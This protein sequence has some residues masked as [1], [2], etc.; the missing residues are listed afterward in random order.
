MNIELIPVIE[1]GYNNQGISTPFDYPYWNNSEIWD[2]YHN[3]CFAKAGFKDKMKPYLAGSSF[4]KPSDISNDNLVKLIKDHTEDMRT[5][6]YSRKQACAFFGGSVLRID[7]QDKYYP[8]CCGLL[9]D[10]NY[11][12]RLANGQN[13]CYEGHPEPEIKIKNTSIVFDFSTNKNEEIFEPTPPERILKIEKYLLKEAVIKAKEELQIL[14]YRIRQININ[15][16]LKI[17][18]IEQLLIWNNTNYE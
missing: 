6:K 5:G 17:D 7:E 16:D 2:N 1:I 4:F 11:W 13:S 12:E 14:A 15:E 8:Q 10:I 18:D 9:S 3:D